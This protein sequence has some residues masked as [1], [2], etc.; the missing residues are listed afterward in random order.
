[1]EA[2]SSDETSW[3]NKFNQLIWSSNR[4]EAALHRAFWT[5]LSNSFIST[6]PHRFGNKKSV[7]LVLLQTARK[8]QKVFN[9]Y[10]D[11]KIAQI[12]K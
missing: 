2:D 1:M 3:T 9:I 12:N 6:D 7:P 4:S 5:N 10:R 8:L 11:S